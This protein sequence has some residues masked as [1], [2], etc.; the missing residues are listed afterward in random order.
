MKAKILVA[1]IVV[2]VLVVS[3][4][5]FVPDYQRAFYVAEAERAEVSNIQAK[6]DYWTKAAE[7]KTSVNYFTHR[8]YEKHIAPKNEGI[9]EKA[10]LSAYAGLAHEL[11]GEKEK[12]I[13]YFSRALEKDPQCVPALAHRARQYLDTGDY[14]KAT[15]DIDGIYNVNPN[16][17]TVYLLRGDLYGKQGQVAQAIAALDQALVLAPG[18]EDILAKKQALLSQSKPSGGPAKPSKI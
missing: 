16:D 9:S 5:M 17:L 3:G 14:A 18:N 7:T 12:A 15:A 11:C 4:N 6:R 2:A 10:F 13:E 8:A 1:L